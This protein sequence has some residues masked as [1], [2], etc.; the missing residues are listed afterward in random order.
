MLTVKRTATFLASLLV[1][2]CSRTPYVCNIMS[3]STGDILTPAENLG[4]CDFPGL[5]RSV[6]RGPTWCTEKPNTFGSVFGPQLGR[7]LQLSYVNQ[8]LVGFSAYCVAPFPINRFPT[9][10]IPFQMACVWLGRSWGNSQ[11]REDHDLDF[12]LVLS[13]FRSDT[14]VSKRCTTPQR[15][16]QT[17]PGAG[18]CLLSFYSNYSPELG[19]RRVMLGR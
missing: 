4:R 11:T 8:N 13:C 3:H 1:A 5:F 14:S 19:A 2:L 12:L 16:V 9:H 15:V 7:R 18:H 10:K 17:P 6:L